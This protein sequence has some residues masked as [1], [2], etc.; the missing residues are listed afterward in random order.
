MINDFFLQ[1]TVEEWLHL[2][3]LEQY[4]KTLTSQGY[5]DMESVTDISWEDLEEIGISKLGKSSLCLPGKK[6][7]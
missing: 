3:N 1:N 4:Y 2:L 7:R 6:V 5:A